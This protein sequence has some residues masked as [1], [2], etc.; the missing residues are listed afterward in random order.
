MVVYNVNGSSMDRPG[1]VVAYGLGG[2]PLRDRVYLIP[3]GT[4]DPLAPLRSLAGWFR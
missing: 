3:A 2:W 1:P 4:A